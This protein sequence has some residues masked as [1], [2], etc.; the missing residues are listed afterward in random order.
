MI[1]DNLED[2][3]EVV[4]FK[5]TLDQGQEAAET[6]EESD[7]DDYVTQDTTAYS[8]STTLRHGV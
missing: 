6:S 8:Q 5:R 7:T 3:S 1:T 2:K 4:G